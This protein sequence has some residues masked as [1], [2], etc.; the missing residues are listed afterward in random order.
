MEEIYNGEKLIVGFSTKCRLNLSNQ[1][2]NMVAHCLL[3]H[4]KFSGP[5]PDLYYIF[6][7]ENTFYVE[8]SRKSLHGDLPK[9]VKKIVAPISTI[10]KIEIAQKNCKECKDKIESL[11]IKTKDQR[12]YYF[13]LEN[14]DKKKKAQYMIDYVEKQKHI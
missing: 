13:Q 7:T 4:N 2:T 11:Y 8:Y 6:L 12:E 5:V 10:D 3:G 9:R 14:E 1:A